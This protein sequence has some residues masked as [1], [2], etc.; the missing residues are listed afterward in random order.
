MKVWKIGSNPKNDLVIAESDV[1]SF[2]AELQLTQGQ[3]ILRDLGT[4][5]PTFVNDW[6]VR[7]KLIQPTD[8][9]IIGKTVVDI[10]DLIIKKPKAWDEGKAAETTTLNTETSLT[11]EQAAQ[12]L[13]LKG[14][15]PA[16]DVVFNFSRELSKLNKLLKEAPLP[17][18]KR[19]YTQQIQSITQAKEVLLKGVDLENLP[20]NDPIKK[21]YTNNPVI[22][23]NPVKSDKTEN[24][25]PKK[26]YQNHMILWGAIGA[27]FAWSAFLM[28]ER[29]S[30]SRANL[31]IDQKSRIKY[32]FLERNFVPRPLIISNQTGVPIDI[33]GFVVITADST[34]KGWRVKKAFQQ[35]PLTLK[36]GAE[37][38]I[39]IAEKVIFADI[40]FEYTND[41]SSEPIR[42]Q[43][44]GILSPDSEDFNS[45]NNALEI[46]LP[47]QHNP[48]SFKR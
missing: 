41:S 20:V 29:F 13:G 38:E 21:N 45:T 10:D 4:G 42:A 37:Q 47:N 9:L 43:F 46:R 19:E 34:D 33:L 1:A 32:D 27:L 8:K 2:H 5:H 31:I 24:Q 39:K 22:D 11:K 48:R 18:Q 16:E 15:A 23:L 28:Y 14:D 12:L 3:L 25:A 30:D 40:V 36:G 35:W 26:W 44:A 17:S 7:Q 6:R